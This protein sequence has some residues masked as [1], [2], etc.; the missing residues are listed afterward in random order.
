MIEFF[1]G[2]FI[3]AFI[4]AIIAESKGRESVLWFIYALFLWPIALVHILVV[5]PANREAC[6]HCA[7]QISKDAK[8]C[9]NCG[10]NLIS[11]GNSNIRRMPSIPQQEVLSSKEKNQDGSRKLI[12]PVSYRSRGLSGNPD[13]PH[14]A[15]LECDSSSVLKN[16]DVKQLQKDD[17]DE[18][19]KIAIIVSSAA[20]LF[21]LI[22]V[23][24][25]FLTP[26][27]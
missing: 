21:L 23:L 15:G 2:S 10:N 27:V 6:P 26:A 4:P 14:Q 18:G 8:V 7:E 11:S 16:G 3:L 12:I 5:T 22:I 20:F 13:E 25:F 19:E 1:L 9:P 17:N 24:A